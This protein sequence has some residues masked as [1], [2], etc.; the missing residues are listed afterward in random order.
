[1]SEIFI[2]RQPILDKSMQVFAYELEFHKGLS[3]SKEHLN[4]TIDLI[5]KTEKEVGFQSIVGDNAVMISFSKE[6][7]KMET[8]E[9]LNLTSNLVLEIPNDVLKDTE[10]LKVLKDIK[11][12]GGEIAL[13]SYMGDKASTKLIDICNLAKIDNDEFTE[14]QLKAMISELH[15]KGLKVIAQKVETEESFN[16]L[17][18]IGFDYFT[19]HFFTNPVVINGKKL[20]GNKLTLLQLMV[21]INDPK[22]EIHELSKIISQDVALSHKLLLAVNKPSSAIPVK[23][24][25]VGDAIGY[26]GLKRLKFWINMLLLGKLS[27]VPRELM[28]SSLIRAKF[29][30]SIAIDSGHRVDKDSYFLVGLFSSL[31]AFFKAPIAEIVAEMPLADDVI[32]ALID[33]KGNMGEALVCL[34][35]I[36]STHTSHTDLE[37]QGLG[38][39]EIAN[40]YLSSSAWA[41]DAI[42]A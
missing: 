19:G 13:E 35:K 7:I 4:A 25:S 31:G 37:F 40:T 22:L 33:K 12:K 11:S 38:I 39:S 9:S 24:E 29:C 16:Y 21:K 6:L 26:M 34:G 41:Q 14:T 15:E 42:S 18:S 23:V 1:M 36:E 30:E 17:K 28:V 10:S 3:P 5:I 32:K 2:G 20:S 8:I 27:D